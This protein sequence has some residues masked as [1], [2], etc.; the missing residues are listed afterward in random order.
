MAPCDAVETPHQYTHTIGQRKDKDP[1]L[2]GVVTWMMPPMFGICS[3]YP[4]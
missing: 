2:E 4:F 3:H 1:V